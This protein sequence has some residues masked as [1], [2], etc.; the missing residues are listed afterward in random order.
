MP[1]AWTPERGG[2]L[3]GHAGGDPPPPPE[4]TPASPDR[5]MVRVPTGPCSPRPEGP[6]PVLGPG[7]RIDAARGTGSRHRRHDR[8][9]PHR[10]R[11]HHVHGHGHRRSRRH[12]RGSGQHHHR[13]AAASGDQSGLARPRHGRG[14]LWSRPGRDRECAP[15]VGPGSRVGAAAGRPRH[16]RRRP[17]RWNSHD[18]GYHHG[19]RDGHQP[20]RLDDAGLGQHHHRCA[21]AS[22]DQSGLA[23]PRHGRGGLWSRPGRE[24]ECASVVGPGSWS[25]PLPAGL[26]IGVDG[27]IAG[28]PTAA[29][30]T[31][32]TVLVPDRYGSTTR[33][34]SASPSTPPR[35]S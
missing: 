34:R 31:T 2:R 15:V 10:T 19:H 27:R 11:E 8:R 6:R 17:D 20:L 3:P 24:R 12:G 18:G 1:W 14:G 9:N 33:P 35:P 28:T 21:A 22:G 23:R 16:R 13:C 29:G 7:R 5:G 25:A 26:A 30:T 32:V 4:I